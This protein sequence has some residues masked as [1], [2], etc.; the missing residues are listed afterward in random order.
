MGRKPFVIAYGRHYCLR[1]TSR[2]FP[3][4][5]LERFTEV[6]GTLLRSANA[7]RSRKEQPKLAWCWHC[8]RL[9]E[10]FQ[11]TLN[12]LMR[13][14]S[15]RKGVRIRRRRVVAVTNVIHLRRKSA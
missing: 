6:G 11:E 5:T 4:D 10:T 1:C 2:V 12:D 8:N 13:R 3:Y 7:T 15:G 9:V 14:Y